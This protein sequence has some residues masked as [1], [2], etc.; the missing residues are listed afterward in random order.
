MA[1]KSSL[2]IVLVLVVGLM[3]AWGIAPLRAATYPEKPITIIVPFSAGSGTDLDARGIAIYLEK[4]LGVPVKIENVMGAEGKLGLTKLWRSKPDGY[5]LLIHT[6]AQSLMGDMILRNV[7][8]HSADFSHVGTFTVGNS[9][10]V[11]HADSWKT[12]PELVKAGQERALIGGN[13]GKGTPSHYNAVALAK[14]LGM[15]VNWV[16]FSGAGEALSALAG[17]H[18][19]FSIHTSP[20]ILSLVKAGKIRPVV[21]MSDVKDI[22]FPEVPIV[23]ELGYNVEFLGVIRALDGPPKMPESVLQVLEKALGQAVKDPG[24]V[25]WAQ[26]RMSQI[27]HLNREEY[28]RLIQSQARELQEN[29]DVLEA[30]K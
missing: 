22:V 4:H 17:K 6:E 12:F 16:P 23:K 27:F 24:F 29:K 30:M 25:A 7:E 3:L 15:K 14:K 20:S 13:P 8:Y 19:E 26:N 9:V 10:I 11:C 5:T 2:G 18:T 1:R 21:V 28:Q